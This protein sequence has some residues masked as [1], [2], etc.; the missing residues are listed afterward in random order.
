MGDSTGTWAY[1]GWPNLRTIFCQLFHTAAP[2]FCYR[3]SSSFS[4]LSHTACPSRWNPR[5]K[6]AAMSRSNPCLGVHWFLGTVAVE[7][8]FAS[9]PKSW[10]P[11]CWT[12]NSHNQANQN[13]VRV[14]VCV[15]RP[16]R[17][18]W[19]VGFWEHWQVGFWD[20]WQVIYTSMFIEKHIPSHGVCV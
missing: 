20:H 18:H 13:R 1:R 10:P 17:P 12:G 6:M 19:Q 3:V 16:I 11:E 2:R 7:L 5:I 14:C 4:H 9:E 8:T 15:G